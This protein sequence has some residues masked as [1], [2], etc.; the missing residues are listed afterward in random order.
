[1]LSSI[2]GAVLWEPTAR[3]GS[4]PVL[5]VAE[6]DAVPRQLSVERSVAVRIHKV[7]S[8]VRVVGVAILRFDESLQ[9]TGSV[10]EAAPVVRKYAGDGYLA[11]MM[12][13]DVGRFF[14]R[15]THFSVV[16]T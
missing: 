2:A 4:L 16:P 13:R 1:M 14:T 5:T 6:L 10:G 3:G 8:K 9:S 12:V 11:F 7:E 15:L